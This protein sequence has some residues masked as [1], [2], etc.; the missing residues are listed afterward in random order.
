MWYR[1]L[2]RL[3]EAKR[4]RAAAN[5]ITLRKQLDSDIPSKDADDHLLLATWNIRDLGKLNRRGFGDRLKESHFYIAEVLSR[6]DFVA[7]Q[8]VNELDEWKIIMDLLGHDY[9]YI[10]T[11]VTD[12]SLGGNGERLTYLYDRRKVSFQDIAGEIVL[13]AKLTITS[14]VKARAKDRGAAIKVEETEVGTQFSRTP[15]TALFRSGWFKFEICTVHIYYGAESG[16]KLARRVK[17]IETIAKYFGKR[18]E[19]DFEDGRS[20]VVLGDFN[21]VHPEHATMN[22]LVKA[23]FSVP[24]PLRDAPSNVGRN[25]HYD[26]IAFRLRPDAPD[27]FASDP[28][29]AAP[30]AGVFEIF[31]NVFSDE[32]AGK[33]QA[34]AA[35]TP[36]GDDLAGAELDRYY[37]TWRTYQ[38]SDHL[39]MWVR[40][41]VNDSDSYL[42][43]L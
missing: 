11:D 10:A 20:L 42:A 3:D 22:A 41:R 31:K 29:D 39:P 37:R 2:K 17:E 23:G 5:L 18:A 36:N 21:I 27:Y 26:Q 30:N 14:N 13:P 32:Q 40:L 9:G 4:Q 15:F 24:A 16:P 8:E 28:G 6:F 35:A 43:S 38:F 19:K 12:P 7:V 34:D 1:S 33:F 25:K